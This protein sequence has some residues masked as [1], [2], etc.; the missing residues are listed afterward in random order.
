MLLGTRGHLLTEV[1]FIHLSCHQQIES[2]K[3]KMGFLTP[4][5][6]HSSWA[7]ARCSRKTPANRV[8]PFIGSLE[9]HPD[10]T[11][12]DAPLLSDL[13]ASKT[14]NKISHLS[15]L[16]KFP[17]PSNEILLYSVRMWNRM[18]L[19]LSVCQSIK[20]INSFLCSFIHSFIHSFVRLFVHSLT[21]SLI[22][23]SLIHSVSQPA[24]HQC[25][26]FLDWLVQLASQSVPQSIMCWC[27]SFI[28]GG[29]LFISSKIVM[30]R[31]TYC[32]IFSHVIQSH[33]NNFTWQAS[34]PPLQKKHGW[35]W[36]GK[37]PLPYLAA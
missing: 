5:P 4:R 36:P 13:D 32:I 20:S 1:I 26:W 25:H 27:T 18:F 2:F 22:H 10:N 7:T 16:L 19:Y 33:D 3:I 29:I 23:H 11:F 37:I 8:E 21:H 24:S 34:F 15:C 31:S 14:R 6:R 17:D 12:W 9:D 35:L 28:P 30:R